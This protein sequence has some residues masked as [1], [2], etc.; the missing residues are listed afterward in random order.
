MKLS[1]PSKNLF[2]ISTVIF[3]LGI[4]AALVTSFGLGSYAV[5]IVSIA[6][7]LLAIGT[8]VKGA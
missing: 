7:L 3:I 5:W 2:Y 8:L 6:F 4:L 1:A